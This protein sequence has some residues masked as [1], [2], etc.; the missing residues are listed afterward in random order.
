MI[1]YSNLTANKCVVYSSSLGLQLFEQLDALRH[2][3]STH[4]QIGS[5]Y[6]STISLSS[7]VFYHPEICDKLGATASGFDEGME[8]EKREDRAMMHYR[9]AYHYYVKNDIGP[10]LVIILIDMC[11]LYLNSFQTTESNYKIQQLLTS[12]V[13]IKDGGKEVE[14]IYLLPLAGGALQAVIETK[15]TFCTAVLSRYGNLMEAL[16]GEVISR[17]L[18]IFLLL[19]K[20]ATKGYT[21]PCPV[22]LKNIYLNLAQDYKMP[23]LQASTW[24][25]TS[26]SSAS[27][28]TSLSTGIRISPSKRIVEVL[29]LLHAHSWI[30]DNFM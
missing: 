3:A 5:Y 2:R 27:I 29:E 12:T 1:I 19:F 16:A 14:G 30:N 24:M 20:L 18:K 23:E 7:E 11:D 4:F 22:D 13:G 6:M 25:D 26:P 9:E 15:L 17:T 21:S 28:S 10:N 8:N